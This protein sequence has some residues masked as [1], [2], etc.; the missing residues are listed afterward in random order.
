MLTNEQL[1]VV[2]RCAGM[3]KRACG[4]LKRIIFDLA[5]DDQK[6]TVHFEVH[7][8]IKIAIDNEDKPCKV[9]DMMDG[10]V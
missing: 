2:D 6:D 10:K 4:G 1:K 8:K 5:P 7:G 3:L 9:V